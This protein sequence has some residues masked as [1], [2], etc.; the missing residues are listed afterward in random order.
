MHATALPVAAKLLQTLKPFAMPTPEA[1]RPYWANT[2]LICIVGSLRRMKPEVSDIEL[3][4]VPDMTTR[5]IDF[6]TEQPF[7]RLA[8]AVDKLVDGGVL[9]KRKNVNG[10]LCWGDKNKHAVDVATGIPVDLFATT[11]ENWWVS[12][13]IRTGSKETNLKLTTGANAQGASLNAYGC[14]VT[15]SDGTTTPAINEEHVFNMC[16]VKFVEASKR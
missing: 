11:P 1:M 3:L 14:G 6:F 2:H 9:T 8:E 15:W 16:K 7:D 4:F 5:K 10:H 13:V 12:L